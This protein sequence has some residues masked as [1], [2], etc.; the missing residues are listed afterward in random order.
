MSLESG[1]LASDG[2]KT[3]DN[4]LTGNDL[5]IKNEPYVLSDAEL[6]AMA[7]DRQKKDNHNMSKCFLVMYAYL[8]NKIVL[9][10]NVKISKHAVGRYNIG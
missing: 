4:S 6:N 10:V 5:N 8:S 2:F 7:K 1:S 9:R 3:S